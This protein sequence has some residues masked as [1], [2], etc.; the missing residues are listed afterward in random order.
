MDLH[1]S[2]MK[3]DNILCKLYVDTYSDVS[4][5]YETGILETDSDVPIKPTHKHLQSVP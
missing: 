4:H 1:K 3:D 5:D 2:V